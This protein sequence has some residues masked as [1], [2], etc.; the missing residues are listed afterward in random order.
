MLRNLL[1]PEIGAVMGE[2]NMSVSA[3]TLPTLRGSVDTP[4]VDGVVRTEHVVAGDPDLR[5]RVHRPSDEERARPCIYT[6]HS[7]G[8]VMGSYAMEDALCNELCVGLGMIGVAI[9]YR[10]APETPYPGP[11]DDCYRGLEWTFTHAAELGIDQ[12]RIGI[13]GLSAGGGLA[14]ALALLARDRSEF[15]LAFSILDSPMLDDRQITAS[16]MREDLPVWTREA[17][18]FG[19]RSYLGDL[20]GRDDVPY[21]AAP[22][23]ADDLSGLPPTFVSVGALDGFRDEAGDYALRCNQAG[24]P[25]ELHVYPGACHGYQFV[26]D[27]RVTRQAGRD[28]NEWLARMVALSAAG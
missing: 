3:E 6:I 9:D 25:T 2:I 17:N 14:A 8:Y 19:W 10:L 4:P 18:E 20:Y 7:G 13:H 23:R 21:T 27:A 26:A 28:R 16:S 15:Q 12:D 22:A 1:D 5:V 24:V 11:L